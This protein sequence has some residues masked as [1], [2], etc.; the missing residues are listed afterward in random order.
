MGQP[1]RRDIG[2]AF[3]TTWQTTP[4]DLFTPLSAMLVAYYDGDSLMGEAGADSDLRSPC[5]P[6][7]PRQS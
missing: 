4:S 5:R 6:V 7:G 3:T 2:H 1:L